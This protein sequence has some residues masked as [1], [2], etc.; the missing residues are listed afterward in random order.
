MPAIYITIE[1]D[2]ES[3]SSAE[4]ARFRVKLRVQPGGPVLLA[5]ARL[6]PS[7]SKAKAEI[8]SLLGE[9]DWR[10]GVEDIRASVLLEFD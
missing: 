4:G 6:C 3:R 8:E 9:L 10:E 2:R 7:V 5:S 1:R